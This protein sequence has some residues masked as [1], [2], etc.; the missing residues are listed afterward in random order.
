MLLLRDHFLQVHSAVDVW[1][2][3]VAQSFFLKT[4]PLLKIPSMSK[5]QSYLSCRLILGTQTMPAH[6]VCTTALLKPA[7]K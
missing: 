5:D 3:F 4:M 6:S 2:Y 7:Q 1:F